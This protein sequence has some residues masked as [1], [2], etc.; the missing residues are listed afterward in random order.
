MV[1]HLLLHC[2]FSKE[3]WG[4]V[5]ALFGV[6]CVMPKKVVDLL[7]CWQGSFEKHRHI[8]IWR[9]IPHCLMWCV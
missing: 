4:M 5:F 8:A 2:P 1:D 6:H 7:A 9:C 3:V